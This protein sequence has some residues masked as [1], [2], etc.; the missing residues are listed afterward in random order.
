MAE[1]FNIHTAPVT[2]TDAA[3]GL[4]ITIQRGHS[5]LVQGDFRNHLFV[6]SGLIRAE[7]DEIDEALAQQSE[8]EDEKETDI[9]K[10]REQYEQLLGKKAPSAAK[11][12]TLQKAIDEA[13]AQQ[14]DPG[15]NATEIE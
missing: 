14:S 13:L 3:T 8:K 9:T 1:L 11:A 10:L 5:A 15:G 12:E 7:H 4:R 6:K 2:V